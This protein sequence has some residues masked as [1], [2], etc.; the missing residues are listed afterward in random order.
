M[1]G[2]VTGVSGELGRMI[3]GQPFDARAPQLLALVHRAR[4]LL[5]KFNALPSI[6]TAGRNAVLKQLLGGV[7]DGVWIESPFF[8]DFGSNVYLA[9]QT[10]IHTGAVLPDSSNIRIGKHSLIGPGVHIY[11]AFHPAR[12]EDR[13]APGWKPGSESSPYRTQASPVTIG[14]EVWIGGGTIVM[15]GVTIGDR[16]TIGAGSVVA[17]HIP[18]DVVAFGNPCKTQKNLEASKTLPIKGL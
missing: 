16:S 8:C 4:N 6:D 11:T 15:P 12:A 14:D 10:F 5:G 1:T 17:T 7:G 9:D 13:R 3:S 2:P 18:P